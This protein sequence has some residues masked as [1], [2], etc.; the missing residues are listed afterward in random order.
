VIVDAPPIRLMLV[1]DHSLMREGLT[2]LLTRE[3]DLEVVAEASTVATAVAVEADPDV[4]VCDLVLPDG[5]GAEVVRAV[6]ERFPAASILVLTMV[7]NPGDVQQTFSAGARGFMLKEAASSELVH[8]IRRVAAGEDYLQPAMGAALASLRQATTRVHS[9]TCVDLSVR[10]RE[11]LHLIALGHTNTEI[12]RL[13]FLSLRT[14]ESHRANILAKL[15][16]RTRAELVRYA[17]GEGLGS[18]S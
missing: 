17:A 3:P 10:E 14:V 8:A 4:I 2:E 7:D 9:S 12:A 18:T 11:V 5:R 16:L 6:Q 1:D 13:L 15:G